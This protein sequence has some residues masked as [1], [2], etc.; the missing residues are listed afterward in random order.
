MTWRALS[1]GRC[2]HVRGGGGGAGSGL[3]PGGGLGGLY[4]LRVGWPA[5]QARVRRRLGRVQ[6]GL[7]DAQPW[8]G[9]Q[10]VV[11]QLK[12]DSKVCKR[13]FTFHIQVM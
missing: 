6:Q 1:I 3:G 2:L 12:S 10:E 5:A 11:A 13:F 9:S 4:A 7:A 8:G